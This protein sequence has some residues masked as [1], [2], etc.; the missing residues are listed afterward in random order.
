MCL[1]F[2]LV[3]GILLYSDEAQSHIFLGKN[4]HIFLD[5]YLHFSVFTYFLVS[6]SIHAQVRFFF[7]LFLER[8]KCVSLQ[9]PASETTSPFIHTRL[10]VEQQKGLSL[11]AGLSIFAQFMCAYK[12]F[13]YQV[14]SDFS[15]KRC[16]NSLSS[17]QVTSA[18]TANQQESCFQ[19]V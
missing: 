5:K 2:N 19:D 16:H 13:S 17:A 1:T 11:S 18:R 9:N 3:C 7:V 10:F 4:I 8:K 12:L 6:C 14:L 15:A